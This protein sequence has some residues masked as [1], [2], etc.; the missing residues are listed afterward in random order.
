MTIAM[1]EADVMPQTGNVLVFYGSSAVV[2]D[3]S[4]RWDQVLGNRTT[5]KRGTR[6]REFTRSRPADC[7][8]DIELRDENEKQIQWGIYG[9]AR[10][11]LGATSSQR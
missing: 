11:T 2:T 5:I 3:T 8:F 9:G 6:V 1:G 10:I 7:V 4:L